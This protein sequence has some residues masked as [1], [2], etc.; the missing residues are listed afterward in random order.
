MCT[1]QRLRERA[2]PRLGNHR[3]IEWFTFPLAFLCSS[4]GREIWPQAA[5]EKM[6]PCSFAPYRSNSGRY[7]KSAGK[8][9]DQE[10]LAVLK[11]RL[12]RRQARQRLGIEKDHEAQIFGHGLTFFHLEN[13]PLSHALIRAALMMSGLYW[14]GVSNAASVELRHHRIALRRLPAAFDGFTILQLSDLHIDC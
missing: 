4:R 13:L 12:G 6:K 14:R 10:T 2:A 3:G 9:A 11:K 5:L 7:Q 1:S 8:M